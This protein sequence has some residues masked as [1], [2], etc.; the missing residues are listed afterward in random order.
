[1]QIV[2]RVGTAGAWC[3]RDCA[4]FLRGL[5]FTGIRK[6]EA[7]EVEWRDLDFAAGEVVVRGDPETGPKN[8]T[9]RRVPM[10]PDAWSLFEQMRSKRSGESLNE[11]V[12]HVNECQKAL[13]RACKKVGTDRIT[14]RDI[15]LRLGASK[16]AWISRPF[17]VGL[18]IRTAAHWQ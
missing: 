8:W 1:L 13:D 9:V 16:A 2:D 10:I 5:A 15:C 12:F 14:I 11:K 4:D 6:G 18:G 7:A 17:R 3:S